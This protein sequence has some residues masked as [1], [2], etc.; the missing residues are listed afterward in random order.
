MRP[1]VSVSLIKMQFLFKQEK[2]YA[3]KSFWKIYPLNALTMEREENNESSILV[4]TSVPHVLNISAD[5][6]CFEWR[7]KG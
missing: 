2:I 5:D 4:W 3:S 1:K 6:F 7:F